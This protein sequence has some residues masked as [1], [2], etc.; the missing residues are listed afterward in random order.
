LEIISIGES[1]KRIRKSRKLTQV[2]VAN[3]ANISRSYLADLERDRYNASISTLDAIA[4]A[5]NVNTIEILGATIGLETRLNVAL[6][7]SLRLTLMSLSTGPINNRVFSKEVT[8]RLEEEFKNIESR[9]KI[10]FK[11][12][13]D[14]IL[15]VCRAYHDEYLAVE[16]IKALERVKL[17]V[18]EPET[19]AAHH[20]GE[21]WTEEELQE[22]EDFKEFVRMRKRKKEGQ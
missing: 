17:M 2:E 22:I 9:Y 15:D 19:I 8:K 18:D 12:T 14:D 3:K 4:T 6:S 20:D 1:I 11:L 7:E 5:L 10:N 13:P 21:E 16:V